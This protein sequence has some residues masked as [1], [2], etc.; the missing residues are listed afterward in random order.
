M[1]F[2][3]NAVLAE[4]FFQSLSKKQVCS[5]LF[6]VRNGTIEVRNET[7]RVHL[8]MSVACEIRMPHTVRIQGALSAAYKLKMNRGVRCGLSL[9]SLQAECNT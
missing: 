9:R 6:E 1:L 7:A 3:S 5:N 4:S 2:L 8:L